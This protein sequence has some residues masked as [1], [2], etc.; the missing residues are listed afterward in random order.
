LE[1]PTITIGGMARPV[2]LTAADG[3]TLQK[4]YEF[5][6]PALWLINKILG[7]SFQGGFGAYNLTGQFSVIALAIN[8]GAGKK[9]KDPINEAKVAGWLDEMN[10]SISAGKLPETAV[11]DVLW[12]VVAAAF[13]A[14][15]VMQK[16]FDLEAEL[17]DTMRLFFGLKEGEQRETDSVTST[18]EQPGMPSAVR[19]EG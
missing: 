18:S 1:D 2:R 15:W 9:L 7:V 16:P 10:E 13:K 6:S 4:H 11:K 5:E 14:G 19:E 17:P 12:T 8:R 3:A